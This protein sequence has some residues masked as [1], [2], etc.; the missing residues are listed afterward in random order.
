MTNLDFS[1]LKLPLRIIPHRESCE[2][3]DGE[4]RAICCVYYEAKVAR[5]EIMGRLAPDDALIVA[6]IIARTLADAA[7]DRLGR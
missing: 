3:A 1:F 2:I 6:Q 5:R 4:G 7:E